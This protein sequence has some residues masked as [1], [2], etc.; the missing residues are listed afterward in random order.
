[1]TI[2]GFPFAA[3]P[4]AETKL[5]LGNGI[6]IN[7]PSRGNPVRY[8]D[9]DT[10]DDDSGPGCYGRVKSSFWPTDAATSR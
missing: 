8:R 10:Y 4:G 7:A 2:H 5:D 1:M 9:A 3:Q 6:T